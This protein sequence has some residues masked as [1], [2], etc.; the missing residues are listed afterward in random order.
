MGT[1]VFVGVGVA[2]KVNVGVAVRVGVDVDVAVAVGHP[3]KAGVVLPLSYHAV[4][5]EHV[6]FAS[7]ADAIEAYPC[8]EALPSKSAFTP[9]QFP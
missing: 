7:H 1:G 2:V 5:M 3:Q 6:G 4:T 9:V 8:G